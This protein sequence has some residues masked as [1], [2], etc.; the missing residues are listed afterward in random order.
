VSG[1]G[2][3]ILGFGVMRLS[4]QQSLLIKRQAETVFGA[5]AKV[6]LFGSRTDDTA[7][8]GDIDLLVETQEPITDPVRRAAQLSAKLVMSLGEQ[9]FDILVITPQTPLQPIHREAIEKGV[10]L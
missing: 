8:G 1:N 4:P 3:P 5:G 9:R 10:L 7:R 6:R 2:S